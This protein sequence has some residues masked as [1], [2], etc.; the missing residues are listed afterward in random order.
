MMYPFIMTATH[1][2]IERNVI[3]PDRIRK[4]T[5]SFA[6]IEHRFLRDGFLESLSI[7]ERLLYFFLILVSDKNG[8]SWYSY[9]KICAISGLILEEYIEARN[10]LI[11]KDLIAFDGRV[12]Q[13]L[14]LPREPA[15][16][17]SGRVVRGREVPPARTDLTSVGHIFQQILSGKSH[18]R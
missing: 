5:G 12:F 1:G 16:K 14:S 10:G 17:N 3:R 6:F 8:V 15:A 7:H 11:D 4:I 18:D 9:D 13:I 2:K